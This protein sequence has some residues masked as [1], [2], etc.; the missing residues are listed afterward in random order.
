MEEKKLYTQDDKRKILFEKTDWGKVGKELLG[1][2]IRYAQNYHWRTNN[3]RL[4]PKGKTP[5]DIIQEVII[6]TL[7]GK[8][9]WDPNKG[10]LKPWLYDQVKSILD[11][12]AKSA[13]SRYTTYVSNED[14]DTTKQESSIDNISSPDLLLEEQA[15][16]QNNQTDAENKVQLLFDIVNDKPE[17]TQIIEAILEGCEPKPRFLAE[18][19]KQPVENINNALKRLRRYAQKVKSEKT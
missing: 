3:P 6:K 17:L 7:N 9:N 12:L 2:T 4:F 13:D 8:R 5:E 10:D 19:L 15:I 1:F 11:A 18:Y 16:Q 14:N